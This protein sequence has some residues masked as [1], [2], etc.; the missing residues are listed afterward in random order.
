MNNTAISKRRSL[1]ISDTGTHFNGAQAAN[2]FHENVYL[3]GRTYK[4]N[5][6]N[7]SDKK[8]KKKPKMGLLL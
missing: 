4:T 1:I 3:R 7:G 8:K 5:M 2:Y 6:I